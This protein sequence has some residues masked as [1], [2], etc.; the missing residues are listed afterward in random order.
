MRKWVS[1]LVVCTC[2][3]SVVLCA[4]NWPAWRGPTANGVSAE[5]GLP[6]KWSSTE[7]VAWKLALPAYS[8][9]TPIIWGDVI[10]LNVATANATGEL[11]LWAV[12]RNKK[13]P[14][15]KRPIAGG[16][17]IE[18]KQNMSSPSPVT[19]GRNVWVMTG[20]G[21]LKS[22]DFSGKEV[23]SRDIQTDHGR[24][25]LNWGYASS[26]LLHE[27]ALYVQV[28]HGMKTDD[29]S[30]V[31]R[32]DKASG[33][34]LWRVERPTAAQ[35]E[36]PDSYTT[37]LLLQYNGKTEIV[38]SGGDAVTGHDPATGRE[39]WRVDGLNPEQRF[40]YR[41]VASPT[42]MAGLI[43]S[44]SRNNPLTAIRPGG[45]G[46]INA[47]HIAWQF[48]R[49]PDV[50]TPV[51]DGKYV[52]VVGDNGVVFCL[53]VKTGAQIYGPERLPPGT[54][55]ASPILADGKIYVT[56]EQ[57]GL[58]SVFTAGP[59]FELLASNSLGDGCSPYCLSTVAISDGQLFIR[60]SSH[61]WVIGERKT[62]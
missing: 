32:I 43:V 54:Y 60:S 24:F 51:S 55:S 25:G 14:V 23:W 21:V 17:H 53:D 18:R 28:L 30:Y 59:K 47:T 13:M 58:T 48:D 5:T 52:Y 16:N 35:R 22:F 40:D 20:V 39:L 45:S 44:P 10:F 27:D 2:L 11:E 6:V 56:T 33:K 31:L 1:S 8:G 19:D 12:D 37:P 7:N 49:G 57:E 29:P 38:I 4:D 42:V 41:I 36:S 50:P 3:G 61:L 62:K 9:S 15:W 26:P 46:H 34:T